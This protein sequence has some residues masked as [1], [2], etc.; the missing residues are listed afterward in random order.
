MRRRT[1]AP[2]GLTSQPAGFRRG[3][4]PAPARQVDAG[5]ARCPSPLAPA[6]TGLRSSAGVRHL[7]PVCLSLTRPLGTQVAMYTLAAC[8][9]VLTNRVH[10]PGPRPWGA[11]PGGRPVRLSTSG[12]ISQLHVSCGP[13]PRPPKLFD[14]RAAMPPTGA[15][16]PSRPERAPHEPPCGPHE[17]LHMPWQDRRRTR[18]AAGDARETE[19]Q[20]FDTGVAWS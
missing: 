9:S 20:V 17:H 15:A 3:D 8:Q 7:C 6:A 19:A 13:V 4:R 5:G 1:P 10:G 14:A 18:M 2:A 16:I 12:Y 11:R